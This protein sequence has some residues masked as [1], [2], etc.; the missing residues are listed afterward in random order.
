MTTEATTLVLVFSPWVV[1]LVW[2]L[3]LIAR[4]LHERPR[5]PTIS[6]TM[7]A[8]ARDQL[9]LVYLWGGMATH[10][11]APWRAASVAGSLAFWLIAVGLL[12]WDVTRWAKPQ[13]R[14]S[15]E[16]WARWPP[17]WLILGAL[18]GLVLFPQA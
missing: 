8:R 11:W 15:W 3:I 18:G 7:A 1:W 9:T 4:R 16:A 2:E 14:P 10:W 5:P 6:M 17:A 13:W 12:A